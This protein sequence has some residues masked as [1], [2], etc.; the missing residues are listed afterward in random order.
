MDKKLT[1]VRASDKI[2]K[3]LGIDQQDTAEALSA[4]ETDAALAVEERRYR[5]ELADL[6]AEFEKRRQTAQREHLGRV[7]EIS[8]SLDT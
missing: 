7:A 1:I 2:T 3:A 5:R 4:D 8:S 6:Q